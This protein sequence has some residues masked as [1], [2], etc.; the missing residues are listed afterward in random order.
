MK[1]LISRLKSDA[2][3]NNI[4]ALVKCLIIEELELINEIL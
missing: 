1:I 2:I 4:L 3:I